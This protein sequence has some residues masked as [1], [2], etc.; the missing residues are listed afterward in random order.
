MDGLHTEYREN[1]ISI[2]ADFK[3]ILPWIGQFNI[4]IANPSIVMK[5]TATL[6]AM[7]VECSVYIRHSHNAA[8]A[9]ASN[10]SHVQHCIRSIVTEGKK[11]SRILCYNKYARWHKRSHGLW[12]IHKVITVKIAVCCRWIDRSN[13][14]KSHAHSM[15]TYVYVC[16][17]KQTRVHDT[18]NV[19]HKKWDDSNSNGNSDNSNNN[20]HTNNN[21][22]N[23]SNNYVAKSHALHTSSD[24]EW[25][26]IGFVALC[27]CTFSFNFI[28]FL[29]PM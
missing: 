10:W 25:L 12:S 11:S 24:R 27:V 4:K 26:V 6:F 14:K 9:I 2:I 3:T 13:K 22:K 5:Q 17:C 23:K 15:Y 18:Q 19:W 21:Y 7:D 8:I 1:W 20:N 29:W 16:I 28:E